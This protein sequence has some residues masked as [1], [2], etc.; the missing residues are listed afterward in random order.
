MRSF[1]AYEFNHLIKFGFDPIEL[2]PSLNSEIPVEYITGKVEFLG[3]IF[4]VSKDVLIPRP[5]TEE[6]ISFATEY[7]EDADLDEI[8]FADVGTGSGCI[9]ISFALQ[10]QELGLDFKGFL[11]DISEEALEITKKNLQELYYKNPEIK[12][13]TEIEDDLVVLNSNLLNKYPKDIKFDIIFANLPYI[14]SG[15]ISQL[16]SSVKDF[17][18]HKALDGGEDGLE[19][20]RKFLKQAEKFVEKDGIVI[21]EVD[22]THTDTSEFE[23]WDIECKSD[24]NGKNR[25]WV[26]KIKDNR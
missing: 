6:L 14:P 18:P 12:L 25:Y 10:L 2:S 3:H 5:E 15:R 4:K 11:S 20:I 16:Q 1:T 22:D 24:E 13:Q 26:A 9:G 17:E 21:L 19:Y 7:L 23:K 8:I